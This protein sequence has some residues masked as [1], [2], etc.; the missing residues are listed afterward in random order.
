MSVSP[1]P[2]PAPAPSAPLAGLRVLDFTH[3]LAG[4]VCTRLPAAFGADVVRVESRHHLDMARFLGPFPRGR[5]RDQEASGLH[6]SANLG[7]RSLALNLQTAEGRAVA[8]RLG[9]ASDVVVETFRPGVLARLGLGY[10]DL[11]ADKPA[12]VYASLSGFG[13]SGPRA[14]WLSYNATLQACSGLEALTGGPDAPTG[15]GNSWSDYV[16]G[17]HGAFAILAA[18]EARAWSGIGRG[19]ASGRGGADRRS[20]AGGS[21]AGRPGLPGAPAPA[22]GGAVGGGHPTAAFRDA[23]PRGRAGARAR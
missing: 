20:G 22:R 19:R 1:E 7:K 2:T 8:R 5:E 15:V 23:S 18:L 3:V 9:A 21:G 10:A 17:L 16:G 6:L 14:H 4:P 12:L 13:S 11:A